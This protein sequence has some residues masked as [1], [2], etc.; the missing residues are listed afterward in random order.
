MRKALFFVALAAALLACQITVPEPGPTQAPEEPS[1]SPSPAPP[2]E[3][4][5]P[6]PQ[7]PSGGLTDPA[8]E[9]V[10][11]TGDIP[12]TSPFFVETL[13]EPLVLLEDQ[14][15]FVARDIEF[16]FRVESQVIGPVQLGADGT[17]RYALALPAVPQGTFV[18]VDND[19]E[20]DQGVQVFAVAYWS[21][22]WGGPF[23]EERDG[24]AWS[25]G[26]VSTIT[27]P[28]RDGEIEGGILIVWAP[29]D[30]QAFPV[31]FGEDNRLFTE[32]D[33]VESIPAGYS[34]VDLNETPFVF[35]KEPTPEIT[36]YEGALAV[37]DF[38]DR[39]YSDAFEAV[40]EKVSREYPFTADK[41]IDWD[42]LYDE[43]SP[44][45]AAARTDQ[46]FYRAMR[47][48]S[49]HIPDAHVGISLEPQVF[50]EEAGGSFGMR[51]AELDNGDVV[52]IDVLPDEFAD[53]AGIQ[54]G[55][56]ILEWDGQPVQEALDQVEPLFG[57]YS[58]SHSR[59]L[60]QLVFLTRHP[61]QT[62]IEAT[63]QNPGAAAP[64]TA[65]LI[66]T[67]EYDS[68]FDSIPFFAFDEL[69]LPVEA[70]VLDNGF[71]YMRITSF[72]DDFRLT[73]FLWERF[74]DQLIE[75]EI[76][77]LIID[78]RT[79]GGGSAGLASDFAGYFYDETIEVYRRSYFNDVTGQF[80]YS[81]GIADIDPAPLLYEGYVAV[82]VSPHCVSACE[83]FAHMLSLSDRS[84]IIGHFSTAGAFGEVGQGQYELPGGYQMQ[85]PTG[86]PEDMNGDLLIEGIGVP[87]D[88]AVPVTLESTIGG[89]DAVLESAVSWLLDQIN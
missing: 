39:S 74:I 7:P 34:L 65:E 46:D 71:G 62:R 33:P 6:L 68:L 28:E 59:R 29:D 10:Y 27:N 47:D 42:A 43:F 52:V 84:V 49:L 78:L 41:G 11:I 30:M 89:I 86:R 36:L 13:S 66:A 73:A 4:P 67:I 22:T 57:P 79:N 87:L 45:V 16:N 55:A 63:F 75:N 37:N 3:T 53:L 44:Q 85:V 25:T 32:D 9:P 81:P 72:A 76:P 5:T 20:T 19:G 58:T 31:G 61:P 38:S 21:N 64:Q 26:N 48:W 80:E 60:D 77:G 82:L 35:W 40:F 50:F 15:G 69:A 12:Y 2:T 18:D 83:G 56:L 51:L 88:I 1:E 17:L 54:T 8:I 23:L 70:E 24:G 14:A